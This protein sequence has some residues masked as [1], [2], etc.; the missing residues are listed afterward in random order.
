[1][2]S[3]LVL[4]SPEGILPQ[5]PPEEQ[6]RDGQPE[7]RLSSTPAAKRASP[8]SS[9]EVRCVAC[10]R[11]REERGEL[12]AREVDGGGETSVGRAVAGDRC[13]RVREVL[14]V[15]GAEGDPD[16]HLR[17]G[18][19]D[20]QRPQHLVSSQP[21]GGRGEPLLPLPNYPI[22]CPLRRVEKIRSRRTP[23]ARATTLERRSLARQFA[24]IF[25][26][27]KTF[28]SALSKQ[29]TS[30]SRRRRTRRRRRSTC[31]GAKF[32][33]EEANMERQNSFQLL[34]SAFCVGK[35]PSFIIKS[36]L[37]QPAEL[38]WRS[39]IRK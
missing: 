28:R 8:F 19:E 31:G 7:R 32:K 35:I 1:M 33:R 12:R 11:A 22:Y 30:G 16:H 29:S 23:S 5:L 6:Q 26:L 39:W 21:Q 2:G 10:A 17:E 13:L 36:S 3:F 38:E 34:L 9:L 25:L 18:G 14:T 15:R 24:P 20:R 27:L 37:L 4:S